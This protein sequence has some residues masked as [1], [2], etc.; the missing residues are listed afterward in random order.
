MRETLLVASAAHRARLDPRWLSPMPP[1]P[2]PKVEGRRAQF[3]SLPLPPGEGGLGRVRENA[4]RGEGS[5]RGSA[6]P[7]VV[8]TYGVPRGGVGEG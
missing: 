5:S 2:L 8:I 7:K 6:R 3:G 4:S 1:A